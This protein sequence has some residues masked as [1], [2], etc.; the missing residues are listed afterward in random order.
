MIQYDVIIIGAGA[1]GGVA[2]GVLAEAGKNVLLLER[3]RELSFAGVGRDHL[4]NQRLSQYGHNAGPDID[5]NPRTDESGRTIR[6]H[7]P[8]YQNNAAAVGSGTRVY[9]GQAWRFMPQ[10]FRMASIYGVPE[11]SSLADWPIRYEDLAP[12]Y[13]RAEWEIGV[14]GDHQ[15]MTHLPAYGKPYPMPALTLSHKS[16]VHRSGLLQLGWQH[17]RIPR[18]INSVPYNGRPACVHCQHCVGF[19]CPVDAKNGTQNTMIARALASGNCTLRTEVMVSHL[20][21]DSGGHVT[22]V[23]TIDRTGQVQEIRAAVVVLSCGAV[24]TARLLLNSAT[25]QEPN[26]VGNNN[27][28]VGRHLQGH[29][30]PGGIGLFEEEMYDGFGPGAAIATCKFNHHNDGIVGGGMLADDDILLPIIFWKRTLPP[31]L[32]RWGHANKQ[33]MREH[34]RHV[35]DVRGPVQE[36]PSPDGRVTVNPQVRDRYGIRVAHLSGTTHPE[37]VRVAQFMRERA[38]DWLK[39]SGAIKIWGEVPELRL[40]AGQHQ[41]GTARMGDDPRTSVVDKWCKVHHHDNLFIAD[42]SV[43]VT[44]G[45]FNPVLTIMALAWRTAENIANTW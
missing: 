4:R 13:E 5:G 6:P 29:Y 37:T 36:I 32:P 44:N 12:Y 10:D 26:G 15:T 41:A 21:V 22:G 23:S 19:A 11:G 1:G 28:Q 18:L 35:S 17:L 24:E 40:S 31:D 45:G 42:G 9:A 39:A 20:T 34:Y 27:D 3:G 7:E 16:V 25:P 43:H 8:G 2:A 38:N 14:S 33:F 30:Y